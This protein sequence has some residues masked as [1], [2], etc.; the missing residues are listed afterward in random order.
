MIEA[1][2]ERVG[3]ARAVGQTPKELRRDAGLKLDRNAPLRTLHGVGEDGGP[4]RES[5]FPLPPSGDEEFDRGL[6]ME[7]KRGEWR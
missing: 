6:E 4:P 5:V 1:L 7:G 2:F 3:H